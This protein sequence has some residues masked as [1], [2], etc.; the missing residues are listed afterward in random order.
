MAIWYKVIF[1]TLVTPITYLNNRFAVDIINELKNKEACKRYVE[2][3]C[4]Q[5]SILYDALGN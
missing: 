2:A 3:N 1:V 4:E 5:A